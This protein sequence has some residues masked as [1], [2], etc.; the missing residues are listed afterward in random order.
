M[1]RQNRNSC[2]GQACIEEIRNKININTFKNPHF[3]DLN[4]NSGKIAPLNSSI[5][6]TI[7]QF[8]LAIIS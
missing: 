3:D 8:F 4:S 5:E 1:M 6:G 2:K 7:D